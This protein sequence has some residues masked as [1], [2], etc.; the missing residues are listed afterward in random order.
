M[1]RGHSWRSRT[2]RE[3]LRVVRDR[4]GH[5]EGGL[6]RVWTPSWRFATG[7]DTLREVRDGL[8]TLVEVWD[9]SRDPQGGQGRVG[10]T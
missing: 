4:L 6:G 3:T 10:T 2:G 8:G 5:P 9:R 7:R 1:G